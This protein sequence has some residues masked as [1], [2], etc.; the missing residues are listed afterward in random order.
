MKN[1]IYIT[2]LLLLFVA[3]SGSHGVEEAVSNEN[4]QK[5]FNSKDKAMEHFLNGNVA[6][7]EGDYQTA[8]L[9]YQTALNYDTSGG[10]YY[11]LARSYLASNKLSNAIQ[12]I[13]LAVKNDEGEI[14]YRS[15][16]A[17]IFIS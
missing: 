3:C 10:I 5:V 2:F 16:M 11:A 15:L 9:E 17:D 6:H 8:I 1:I 7:Q 12:S 4:Q 14:E 13:R